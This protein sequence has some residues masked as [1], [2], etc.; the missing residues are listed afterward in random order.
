M[1]LWTSADIATATNGA[2]SAAFD[3]SGVT[4]DSREVGQGD[5]FIALTGEITDGHKFLDQAFDRGAAGAIVSQDTPH[6][7]VLVSDTFAAL[8]SLAKASR[9]RTSA[10][11]V[12][13]TGSAWSAP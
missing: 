3:V 2:A 7:N 10:R 4:F 13:V 5:L 9:A 6:P 8:E 1:T 12:G 11:I